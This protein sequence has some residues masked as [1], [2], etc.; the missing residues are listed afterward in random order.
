MPTKTP[1]VAVCAKCGKYTLQASFINQRCSERHGGKRCE[2][3]FVSTLNAHGDW[4]Q[5]RYCGGTGRE[6]EAECPSCQG[7]G[8]GFIRDGRQY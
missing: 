2:G 1:P 6:G 5:C 8:W 7:T 3:A 4:E